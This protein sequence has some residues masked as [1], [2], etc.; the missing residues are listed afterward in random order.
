M[1]LALTGCIGLQSG[2][3]SAQPASPTTGYNR[4]QRIEPLRAMPQHNQSYAALR[5]STPAR[6]VVMRG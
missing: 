5:H 1:P 6:V 4:Q 3:L 2:R